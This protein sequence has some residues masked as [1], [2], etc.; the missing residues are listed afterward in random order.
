MHSSS[1]DKTI[2]EATDSPRKWYTSIVCWY[3]VFTVVF[4]SH[5][6][7]FGWW[8]PDTALPD[9]DEA[10]TV[11]KI[12]KDCV[13]F[14]FLAIAFF[15]RS[16][17]W[18]RIVAHLR[19]HRAL[20]A[21][22]LAFSLWMMICG[23]ARLLTETP[24]YAILYWIRYPL[25]YLPIIFFAPL[26]I[27]DRRELVQLG[28]VWFALI[29][30][31]LGFLVYEML[32]GTRT[33]FTY[34]GVANRYGSIFGAPND[35]GMY[36][37]ACLIGIV[38]L[39]PHLPGSALWKLLTAGGLLCGLVTSVSR[40][41][42]ICLLIGVV[43]LFLMKVNRKQIAL[44]AAIAAI[45]GGTCF[46]V[47]SDLPVLVYASQRVKGD[48]SAGTRLVQWKITKEQVYEWGPVGIIAGSPKWIHNENYYTAI[49]TRSGFVG[50]GF[51]SAIVLMTLGR[52]WKN[53]KRNE[54]RDILRHPLDAMY[55][56]LFTAV[57]VASL[58]IPC[59]DM[60]PTNFYYW[61]TAALIWSSPV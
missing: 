28:W 30:L 41:A 26:L 21:A 7:I 53:L 59:P 60:F 52:G 37:A 35:F 13:W 3:I 18:H 39:W 15:S 20:V 14:V 40:S 17:D 44:G 50:L 2:T 5:R 48:D 58:F 55:L 23:G 10:P 38:G 31:T 46:I 9:S 51:Y 25:E 16:N 33:G 19:R 12:L 8:A 32:S 56:A 43:A 45:I 54:P 61:S 22:V 47:A 1:E 36:C 57:S 42:G 4:Y 49:L 34:G 11:I 24:Q 27:R 6:F 29:Y